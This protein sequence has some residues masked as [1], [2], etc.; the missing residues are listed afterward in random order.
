MKL[1]NYIAAGAVWLACATTGMAQ[2]PIA[3]MPAGGYHMDLSH[4]SLNWSVNHSGL[5]NYTAR[6]TS[7]SGELHLDPANPAASTISITIDPMSTETDLPFKYKDWND[8]LR[9]A[10]HLFN[11]VAFPQITYTSTGIDMTGE[12][13]GIVHGDL[14]FLGVT[15][16]VD[17]NVT[18]NGAQISNFFTKKPTIGFS[19]TGSIERSDFG[20]N[21]MIPAIGDTITLRIEAEF[22]QEK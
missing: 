8:E 2:T 5:S 7:M 22:E 9:T 1:T 12:Y 14:V 17:L 6:F 18:F 13:T 4:T 15:R 21:A 3:E 10:K 19:A 20:M 11:S 16:N